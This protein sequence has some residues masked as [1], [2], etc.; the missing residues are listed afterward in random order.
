MTSSLEGGDGELL[1][2][3]MASYSDDDHREQ[4]LQSATFGDRMK[5]SKITCRLLQRHVMDGAALKKEYD[6]QYEAI[7]AERKNL[8]GNLKKCIER[9]VNRAIKNATDDDSAKA[10]AI[11]GLL[12]QISTRQ[13]KIVIMA[14]M[15]LSET[16]FDI[17]NK[18]KLKGRS[19]FGVLM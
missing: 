1:R 9:V 14:I 18:L 16:Q 15:N 3:M 4:F 17:E 8:I 11:G 6:E 7:L 2:Q 13:S 19:F 5:A 12:E 10:S